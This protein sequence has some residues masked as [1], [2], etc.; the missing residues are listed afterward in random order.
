MDFKNSP[1]QCLHRQ[2]QMWWNIRNRVHL[3]GGRYSLRSVFEFSQPEKFFMGLSQNLIWVLVIFKGTYATISWINI[4]IH[5]FCHKSF[6]FVQTSLRCFGSL[7]RLFHRN[8]VKLYLCRKMMFSRNTRSF[9][10]GSIWSSVCPCT[11]ANPATRIL[12][13]FI[14]AQL[15]LKNCFSKIISS[16]KLLCWFNFSAGNLYTV[17]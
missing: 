12:N 9:P 11:K 7:G 4:F 14:F 3:E 15:K 16:Q 8:S 5:P 13:S 1:H 6:C 10:R 2:Q 17:N